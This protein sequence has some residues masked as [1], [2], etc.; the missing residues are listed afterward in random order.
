M[1]GARSPV[2]YKHKHVYIAEDDLQRWLAQGNVFRVQDISKAASYIQDI[3]RECEQQM[4]R[5]DEINQ[6]CKLRADQVQYL[7]HHSY[8]LI[9]DMCTIVRPLQSGSHLIATS[10]MRMQ[11]AVY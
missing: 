4:I 5:I 2:T 7:L 11:R 1:A 9:L 8:A 3:Y 10:S 6:I